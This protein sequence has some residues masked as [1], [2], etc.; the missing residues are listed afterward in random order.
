MSHLIRTLIVL[1]TD[2][3]NSGGYFCVAL[4]PSILFADTPSL[5]RSLQVR[6]D[7]HMC[8]NDLNIVVFSVLETK[9]NTKYYKL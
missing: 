9:R 2:L 3:L 8:G 6:D 7:F 4:G 5:C 1:V